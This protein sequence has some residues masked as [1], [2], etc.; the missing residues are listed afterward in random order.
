[1]R[2]KSSSAWAAW[3]PCDPN[4]GELAAGR[5]IELEPTILRGFRTGS[6]Q[7]ARLSFGRE[8]RLMD[9]TIRRADE[10][11]RIR[12]ACAGV[13][14]RLEV[15]RALLDAIAIADALERKQE[16]SGSELRELA[17]AHG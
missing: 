12:R 13:S 17:A 4:S 16:L 15:Q 1:M 9:P 3:E 7:V 8:P 10:T 14:A 2:E 5:L 6:G 11:E